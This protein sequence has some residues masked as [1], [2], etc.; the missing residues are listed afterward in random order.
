MHPN[1][2]LELTIE[3]DLTGIE[4]K[5]HGMKIIGK[6]I[7]SLFFLVLFLAVNS[8]ALPVTG[9]SITVTA[10]ENRP[11]GFAGGEF[12]LTGPGYELISFCVEWNEHISLG[13][14]YTVQSYVDYAANGGGY[15]S[16]GNVSGNEYHDPLSNA[17]KWL[18]NDY[19][20]G[21]LKA[22]Y[23]SKG[24]DFLAGAMQVAIWK[25]EEEPYYDAYKTAYGNLADELLALATTYGANYTFDNVK[26]VNLAIGSTYA[27]SQIVAAP[28]PE[29]ATLLLL[30][31]GLI[32][33]AGF[34]RRKIRK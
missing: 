20:N 4:R 13:G 3:N 27:Q 32:G 29:P 11:A 14:N 7:L 17:T 34:G 1:L 10:G 28:V 25:L 24:S 6:S 2:E 30:G 23:A 33:L 9:D 18:M 12:K 15:S 22:T 19:I 21:D 16:D 26:V 5:G 8:Y 31:S